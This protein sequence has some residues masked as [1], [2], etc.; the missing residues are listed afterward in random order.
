MVKKEIV[1]KKSEFTAATQSR[2]RGSGS[3]GSCRLSDLFL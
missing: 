1:K 3:E 2:R